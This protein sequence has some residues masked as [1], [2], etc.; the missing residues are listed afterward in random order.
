MDGQRRQHLAAD[1]GL[2][3]V[4]PVAP[5]VDAERERAAAA[6]LLHRHVDERRVVL[7]ARVVGPRRPQAAG[8]Q[9][10]RGE[11]GRAR[12][13]R[14][15]RPSGRRRS[16]TGLRRRRRGAGRARPAL[17][18]E[19]ARAACAGP[20]TSTALLGAVAPPLAALTSAARPR[21]RARGAS[22][23]TAGQAARARLLRPPP[24]LWQ[25]ARSIP[26]A[27]A[28]A[29]AVGAPRENAAGAGGRAR[30]RVCEHKV[31][32][33][34]AAAGARSPPPRRR[35]SGNGQA[36]RSPAPARMRRG[37]A[38]PARL[39]EGPSGPAHPSARA[40]RPPRAGPW[41]SVRR[42]GRGA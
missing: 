16:R 24:G 40:S 21:G 38:A 2:G 20:G 1:L 17:R 32:L 23:R 26:R 11:P 3:R 7:L 42:D 25:R 30:R 34:A 41:S 12:P 39:H 10:E 19:R 5:A 27:R 29:R 15:H 37:P 31:P 18:R 28:R 4:E 8:E 9:R 22:A 33:L 14:A 6:G 35:P 13:R 36:R